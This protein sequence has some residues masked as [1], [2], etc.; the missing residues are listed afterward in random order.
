MKKL[1][2]LLAVLALALPLA[3]CPKPATTTVPTESADE[4][5][6]QAFVN[7]HILFDFDRYNVRPDQVSLVEAKAAFLSRF[8]VNAALQGYADERGTEA[9]NL[10]LSDRRAKS[11][12]D[13]LGTLGV[14]GSRLTTIGYGES[15]PISSGTSEDA[16]QLNRRVQTIIR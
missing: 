7:Q 13:Y 4:A 12:K 15:N 2:M 11:V 14:S 1:L 9:Y 8:N 10:A 5:L 3:G 6:R 16:Y